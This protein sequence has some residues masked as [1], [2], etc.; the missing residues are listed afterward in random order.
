MFLKCNDDTDYSNSIYNISNN[1]IYI[2]DNGSNFTLI[3]GVDYSNGINKL[4]NII[5]ENNILNCADIKS[6]LVTSIL[7]D[8][9]IIK[10]NEITLNGTTSRS[11]EYDTTAN[12]KIIS[13]NNIYSK[14]SSI[15]FY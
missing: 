2:K 6:C 15:I 1:Q 12:Y 3:T 14:N 13:N 10:N 8:R 9:L 5:V 11:I 7:C 4:G